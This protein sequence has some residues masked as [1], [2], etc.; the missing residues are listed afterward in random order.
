M[1]D[2]AGCRIFN[3]CFQSKL[4]PC[5][6][7]ALLA[8]SCSLGCIRRRLTVRTNPPGAAVYV[9]HQ[10]IGNSPVSSSLVY[11]GTRQVEVVRDGFRTEKV[12]RKLSPKWYEVPPLDFFFETLWPWEIRDERVI[13]ITM[14]PE[15]PLSSEELSARAN[16]LRLQAG[17]GLATGLPPTAV[18][19]P[20]TFQPG[21][22][23]PTEALPSDRSTSTNGPVLPA[24]QPG[25]I[26]R[27]FL[28]PGGEPV[29]RIPETSSTIGGGY[30]PNLDI[31]EP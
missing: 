18:T 7:L 30:R 23:Y 16:R 20:P 6:L 4:A 24:W 9:D 10:M 2:E 3:R 29:T 15:Q 31:S 25:Q 28:Q 5:F 14:V 19:N 13:D 8:A 27:G 1:L 12:L 21:G 11:E 26:L 17:Q 22:V